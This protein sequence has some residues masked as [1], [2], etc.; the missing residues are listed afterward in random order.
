MIIVGSS[1]S[2]GNPAAKGN[3]RAFDANT[4]DLVW[5]FNTIPE[6]GEDGYDTY[7]D[8]NAYKRLGGANAWAGLTLDEKRGIVYAPTGSVSYDF[9]GGDRLG[10]NL[11]ANSIIALDASSGKKL[12]HFQTVHHDVWDRDLP[13]PPILFDYNYKDN[14]SV[15]SFSH[16]AFKPLP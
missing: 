8:P 14:K 9:Y 5:I 12:W 11:F 15:I 10:D 7:D 2:E 13:S 4:G 1:V 6:I 3:I 16:Y